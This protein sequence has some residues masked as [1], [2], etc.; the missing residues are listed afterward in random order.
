MH[1]ENQPRPC[2]LSRLVKRKQDGFIEF[3]N[4]NAPLT[5][6]KKRV[7]QPAFPL[8]IF[9][10]LFHLKVIT[11]TFAFMRKL[12]LF[13]FSL[14]T[15]AR[16][17]A[18]DTYVPLDQDI[19][20]IINR[21]EIKHGEKLTSLHTSIRPYGRREVA[22]LAE[23][24]ERDPEGLSATDR[25]NLDYLLRE[26]WNYTDRDR[27]LSDR[28]VLR[29]FFRNQADFY[30]VETKDF[31]L[32]INPVL[33]FQVGR[34]TDTEGMRYVN[35]RGIQIEGNVDKRLGFYTFLSENQARFPGYVAERIARDNAV[36]NEGY[37]KPFKVGGYDFFSARGYITY[38]LSRHVNIQL[39]HDRNFIG[40][41]FRSLILSDFAAPNLFLK[42]N[43]KVWKFHYMNLF[44]EYIPFFLFQDQLF[45]RKYAAFHHLSLDLLPN[46]NVG[47]FE[48]VVFSR[49]RGHFELQYLNPVIFY[50]SIE[51]QI[52][53]E[54]NALL[55]ADFKWNI[56]GRAQLYGQLV[57]D[58]FLLANLRSRSGWWANKQ[59]GQIGAKLLDVAGVSNL[60]VQGEFNVIRPYTY[61]HDDQFTNYQHYLQPLAHPIGANL[62]EWLGVVRYQPVGRLNLTAKAAFST[63]GLDTLSS[64][65]GTNVLK[66]YLDPEDRSLAVPEFGNYIGQGIKARQ[67][68]LDLTAS[69]Q[70]RHNMFLDLKQILRRRN[71]ALP[72]LDQSPA[73]TSLSFRWNIPQRLHEF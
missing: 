43:T 64:N 66:S 40:N 48:S 61:Q 22:E 52:G 9:P 55:G 28:P 60:D 44:S 68:H 15:I 7:G 63:Y 14:F 45:P 41:G 38:G 18:Q 27:N 3:I 62:Y 49:R 72:Q 25:F 53:S 51:Q 4:R 33:H 58:E 19:Y 11:F 34:D 70:L 42:L 10:F 71:A 36:P 26:N 65:Y 24:M 32:R 56:R 37:W 17:F 50:R 67:L 20:R 69:W 57:L 31:S 21:Y 59:A 2:R 29:Y 5:L 39:G 30:H 13:A 73:F 23:L 47:L 8:T 16:S 12:C 35:T 46:L 1:L 6:E 54:D